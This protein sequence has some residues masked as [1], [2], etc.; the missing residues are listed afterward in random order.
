MATHRL[1]RND[2]GRIVGVEHVPPDGV[3]HVV[4]LPDDAPS[5]FQAKIEHKP[6]DGVAHVVGRVFYEIAVDHAKG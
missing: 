3:A 2:A 4:T 6:A 1:I 5:F